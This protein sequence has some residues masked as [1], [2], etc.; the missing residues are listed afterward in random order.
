[1]LDVKEIKEVEGLQEHG[2][3]ATVDSYGKMGLIQRVPNTEGDG[4]GYVIHHIAKP[5][6]YTIHLMDKDNMIVKV[7]NEGCSLVHLIKNEY[8]KFFLEPIAHT[9]YEKIQD[10]DNDG[11]A[12]VS[13]CI[14]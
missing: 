13:N 2:I 14:G 8:G 7:G 3:M 1:M 12:F 10:F 5:I 4:Y 11:I 6:R 9:K